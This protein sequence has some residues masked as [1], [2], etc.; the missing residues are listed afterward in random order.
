MSL[1]SALEEVEAFSVGC[2]QSAGNM[3]LVRE[4]TGCFWAFVRRARLG[5][6]CSQTVDFEDDERVD[7]EEVDFV[8]DEEELEEDD[9][10]EEEYDDSLEE[11]RFME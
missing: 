7:A 8:E 3:R 5:F 9:D 2:R 1:L 10:G 11:R 6:C 4:R